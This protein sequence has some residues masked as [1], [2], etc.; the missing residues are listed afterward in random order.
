M[1]EWE[2]LIYHWGSGNPRSIPRNQESAAGQIA[3]IRKYRDRWWVVIDEPGLMVAF[4][5]DRETVW[6]YRKVGST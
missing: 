3:Y 5:K 4:P 6:V 1:S 2:Q